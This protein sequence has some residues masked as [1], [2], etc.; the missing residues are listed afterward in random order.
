MSSTR[1]EQVLRTA[2]T[3][4]VAGQPA[5]PHDRLDG[6]QRRHRQRRQRQLAAIGTA[7]VVAITGAALGVLS[8][9]GGGNHSGQFAKRSVP[10][11]ALSWPDQR[12]PSISPR[13]LDGAIDAWSHEV[14]GNP[15]A[16]QVIWYRAARVADNTEIVVMFEV[17]SDYG[18]ELVVGYA[19]T[20]QVNDGQPGY[21][22]KNADSPWILSRVAAP[23]PASD[24][25]FGLNVA[26]SSAPNPPNTFSDNM[27][28]VMADPRARRFDW[29]V[30]GADGV[31]HRETSPMSLGF[32]AVDAGQI[33]ERVRID[34][35]RDG[36]GKVLAHDV[37]VGVP[38]APES[39]R[40]QLAEIP[41]FTD[42]PD[43]PFEFGA[44]AGQGNLF[45]QGQDTASIPRHGTTIYARCY[46]GAHIVIG[47]DADRP[48]HRVVIS[49]DDKEHVV[50]GPPML[51]HS[52]LAAEIYDPHG[53]T[54][55]DSPGP[56]SHAID[57]SASEDTAWRVSVIAH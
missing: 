26:D 12:D 23:I 36:A 6:V 15:V 5:A 11:W 4:A 24:L 39:Y 19:D 22:V 13:V 34:A 40:V 35:V 57:I 54:A 25:V 53:S 33:K 18:H 27:I 9:G 7:A 43:S 56:N 32:A 49:C 21:D 29:H 17:D 28:V 30:T 45:D 47:I 10:A 31:V 41:A 38:G 37:Q 8:A 3:D 46:G 2:L 20:G 51:A 42:V 14:G 52:E 44:S 1:E 55:G 48:G 50:S 16:K